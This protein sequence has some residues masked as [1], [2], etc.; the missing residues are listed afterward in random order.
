M[1][2]LCSV[3]C[4]AKHTITPLLFWKHKLRDWPLVILTQYKWAKHLHWYLQFT[5]FVRIE[6]TNDTIKT[7]KRKTT[8]MKSSLSLF[9]LQRNNLRTESIRKLLSNWAGGNGRVEHQIRYQLALFWRCF[10][11]KKKSFLCATINI[12]GI[13]NSCDGILHRRIIRVPICCKSGMQKNRFFFSNIIFLK[14]I[15]R[16]SVLNK[17]F[18]DIVERR[19]NNGEDWLIFNKNLF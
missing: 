5:I 17:Q 1:V 16:N 14:E 13:M 6:K 19:S 8:K 2:R 7:A 10:F 3:T 4:K 11:K 9:L 12:V 15:L 18:I